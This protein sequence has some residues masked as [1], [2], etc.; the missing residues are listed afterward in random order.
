[1]AHLYWKH[2][3]RLVKMQP[4]TTESVS[5]TGFRHHISD[6]LLQQFWYRKKNG[7]QSSHHHTP[8]LILSIPTLGSAFGAPPSS[9]NLG[10]RVMPLRSWPTVILYAV[11]FF[12]QQRSEA[13]LWK[14]MA[15]SEG[16]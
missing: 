11:S 16:M 7:N 8:F 5:E 13:Q 10:I 6:K 9:S 1:M 15:P 2:Q 4:R 3:K 12:S 14:E